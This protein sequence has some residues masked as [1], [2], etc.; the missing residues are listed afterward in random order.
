MQQFMILILACSFLLLIPTEANLRARAFYAI[1][2]QDPEPEVEVV[3]KPYDNLVF[4]ENAGNDPRCIF[5][6]PG[7]GKRLIFAPSEDG[8]KGLALN[9]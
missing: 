1:T 7:M 5:C 8:Q 3:G 2:N 4:M 6:R 9:H